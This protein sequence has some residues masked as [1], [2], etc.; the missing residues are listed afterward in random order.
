M[1]PSRVKE[2]IEKSLYERNLAGL[3]KYG[4]SIEDG[5]PPTGWWW[6][7]VIQELLDALQYMSRLLMEYED[8]IKD[9]ERQLK[10][11]EQSTTNNH[12]CADKA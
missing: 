5:R 7:E 8:K 12:S 2:Y 10:E 4:V 11:I 3:K 9:L 6:L 1:E